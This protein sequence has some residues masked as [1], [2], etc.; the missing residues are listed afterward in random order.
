MKKSTKTNLIWGAA[1]LGALVIALFAYNTYF[2]AYN[3]CLRDA[4]ERGTSPLNAKIKCEGQH[5]G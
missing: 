2:S 5:G 3:V 4:L 1:T